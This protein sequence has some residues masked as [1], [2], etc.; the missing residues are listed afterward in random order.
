M[1]LGGHEAGCQV[2]GTCSGPTSS[3]SVERDE[4]MLWISGSALDLIGAS[5]TTDVIR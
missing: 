4:D 5:G 1:G 2:A 3:A